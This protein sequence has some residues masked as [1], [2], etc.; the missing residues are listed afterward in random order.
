MTSRNYTNNIVDTLPWCFLF[1]HILTTVLHINILRLAYIL[2]HTVC[3]DPLLMWI[4]R[5]T[6]GLEK[7]LTRGE[8]VLKW[9]NTCSEYVHFMNSNFYSIC[10][11]YRFY[12]SS[13]A[14]KLLRRGDKEENITYMSYCT[15]LIYFTICQLDDP[16][17][18]ICPPLTSNGRLCLLQQNRL[19]RKWQQLQE[20]PQL[21]TAIN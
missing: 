14:P 6:F 11:N 19:Q 7:K 10:T 5:G 18:W 20:K 16:R 4:E 17:N 15:I 8:V 3:V 12:V 21:E 13:F 1:N 9:Q 2:Y